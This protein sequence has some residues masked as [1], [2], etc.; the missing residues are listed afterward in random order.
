MGRR[1]VID[2]ETSKEVD[3][4]VCDICGMAFGDPEGPRSSEPDEEYEAMFGEK[5]DGSQ[6]TVCDDCYG[7][8]LRHMP[9]AEEG[10]L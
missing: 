4:W 6:A 3:G 10:A 1:R 5:V 8:A 7:W 9:V 2:P